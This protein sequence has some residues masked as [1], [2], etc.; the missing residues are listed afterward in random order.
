MI[1]GTNNVFEIGYYSQAMKMEDNNVIE[2]KASVGR[3]VILRSGCIIGTCCNLN[4]F[5]V[6]LENTVICG[7]DCL[8]GVQ[9]E[10]PQPQIPQL[11]FLK[12]TLPT[13]HDLKKTMKGRST[14]VMCED[15]SE[16]PPKDLVIR[17]P[18]RVKLLKSTCGKVVSVYLSRLTV[19]QDSPLL[20]QLQ[21]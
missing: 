6:I 7:A 9:T 15:N 20:V 4:T 21:A 16:I 13:Y 17:Y 19:P 18:Q 3:K 12:I 14:P 2:S 10:Q 1:I 11:D 8:H 5:E